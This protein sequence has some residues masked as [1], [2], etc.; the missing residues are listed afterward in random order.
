MPTV[1]GLLV[2]LALGMCV[3]CTGGRSASTLPSATS[4]PRQLPLIGR[5]TADRFTELAWRLDSRSGDDV[6]VAVS[7]GC[8]GPPTAA[9]VAP[10]AR[11]VRLHVVAPRVAAGT[12]CAANLTMGRFDIDLPAGDGSRL[13]S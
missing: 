12:I 10:V 7:F 8:T 5:P 1:M 3:G 2:A 11:L 6:V 9:W 4:A 13:A